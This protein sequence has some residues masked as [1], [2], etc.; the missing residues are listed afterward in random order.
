MGAFAYQALDAEGRTQTGVL[1]ADT[2]RAARSL[3]RDK[4]LSPLEVTP[5]TEANQGNGIPGLG[6][7]GLSATQL[8]VLT[9]QLAT[10]IRAGL[11]IDEA[12]SALADEA[13]D[14]RLRAIVAALRSRVMEGRT[15]AASM[16]EFPQSFPEIVCATVQA[17]E[18]SGQLDEA[19]ERLADY[20]ESRDTLNRELIS[21]FAYPI[22]LLSVAAA[23]V[24][25]LMISVV[26][27]VVDVFSNLGAKLPLLTRALIQVSALLS[28]YGWFL[29]LVIVV[30]I[31]GW[32]LA[33][34]SPQMRHRVDAFWLGLPLLGRVV[35]A[36]ETA[37]VTRTLAVLTGAGVPALEA[38]RLAAQTLKR[39]PL[40][41]AMRRAAQRVREGTAIAR[42]LGETRAFP[43]VALRLIASGE[44]S[45]RLA[46]M[47]DAAAVQ[48]AREVKSALDL[49]RAILA[50][51]VILFVGVLVLVIVLAILLP[52]FELNTLIGAP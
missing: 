18:Q 46:E 5:A 43:P 33:L 16:A 9:Q 25:G 49:V 7:R 34:R 19:L 4:G 37:R 39:L 48:Q 22:L 45:G 44:R 27:R 36:A 15:L 12:L 10:L 40:Q 31:V 21:A 6:R 28:H 26:P 51:L 1:Q 29:L 17:G 13:S 42:A 38:L 52:I 11:P 24:A 23:V 2:A 35:R 50:P 32:R 14:Q 41:E 20:A 3:L 30:A 8:V 47:F